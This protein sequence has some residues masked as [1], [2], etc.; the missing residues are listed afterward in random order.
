MVRVCLQGDSPSKHREGPS[1][2]LSESS[3]A[4]LED[5]SQ[6]VKLL[7]PQQDV[8]HATAVDLGQL[9]H[10]LAVAGSVND[11]VSSFWRVFCVY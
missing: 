10:T 4:S 7:R 9:K 8:T 2:D 5:L 11:L 1:G 6:L 3:L